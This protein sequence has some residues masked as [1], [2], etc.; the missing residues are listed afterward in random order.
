MHAFVG[1]YVILYD[2]FGLTRVELSTG[3]VKHNK[4]VVGEDGWANST[5]LVGHSEV[6]NNRFAMT[7]PEL[8]VVPVD[9]NWN[10]NLKYGTAIGV[11]PDGLPFEI[12]E[13]TLV[14]YKVDGKE[15]HRITIAPKA[16]KASVDLGPALGVEN[17]QVT[18]STVMGSDGTFVVVGGQEIFGG[19]LKGKQV[20]GA[21]SIPVARTQGQLQM[22]AGAFGAFVAAWHPAEQ[23]AYCVLVA[24]GKV[25][26]E[27]VASSAQVDFDGTRIVFQ[28]SPTEVHRKVFGESVIDR[29]GIPQPGIGTVMADGERVL[30]VPPDR[31]RVRDLINDE[32]VERGLPEAEL[33][34]RKKVLAFVERFRGPANA[35]NLDLRLKALRPPAYGQGPRPDWSWGE[36]DQGLLRVFVVG[37]LLAKSYEDRDLSAGSYSPP[38]TLAAVKADDVDRLLA[39]VREHDLDFLAGLT[40]LDYALSNNWDSRWGNEK[41][42]KPLF[43]KAAAKKLLAATLHELGVPRGHVTPDAIIA[44]LDPSTEVWRRGDHS[45]AQKVAGYLVLE[46][47]EADAY[48]IIVDW[49]VERPSGM[50]QANMHIMADIAKALVTSYPAAKKPFD[51][52]VEKALAGADD[53]KKQRVEYL[54][55]TLAR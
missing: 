24:N 19:K 42:A 40:M 2:C 32:I 51:A 39:A 16:L 4:K 38:T 28:P 13:R 44:A 3:K 22:R 50:V 43:E 41:K 55:Q 53:E 10:Y 5:L 49:L 18:A 45:H 54:R 8:K 15:K 27:T 31:E 46:C 11:T 36:G 33:P 30:F 37:N 26:T 29:L 17:H 7:L 25:K 47:F 6:S 48:P 14:V 34:N 12:T 35:A 21:W 9:D 52:A 20:D 1:D 23:R